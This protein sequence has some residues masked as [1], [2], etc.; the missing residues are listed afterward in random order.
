MN[1][2]LVIGLII[3]IAIV[4]QA[5]KKG[6]KDKQ[7]G[8]GAENF[9]FPDMPENQPK[10]TGDDFDPWDFKTLGDLLNGKPISQPKTFDAER[11]KEANQE[12]RARHFLDDFDSEDATQ[13]SSNAQ[14][15]L[16]PQMKFQ[17]LPDMSENQEVK[18]IAEV[19]KKAKDAKMAGKEISELGVQSS[20]PE[21]MKVDLGKDLKRAIVYSEILSPKFRE[22]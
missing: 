20:I 16:P 7:A 21:K 2:F 1:M 15:Q 11:V 8:G 5:N 19:V 14:M 6:A 18:G 22:Y 17:P 13:N 3:V 9:P 10:S 4:N 12:K